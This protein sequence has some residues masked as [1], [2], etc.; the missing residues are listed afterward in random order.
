MTTSPSLHDL[1]GAECSGIGFRPLDRAVC[2]YAQYRGVQ[3]AATGGDEAAAVQALRDKV[4]R[5]LPQLQALREV[6][7]VEDV[8]LVQEQL[9]QQP[10]RYFARPMAPE[11]A[12]LELDLG[13]AGSILFREEGRG[14]FAVVS[15][16]VDG[17][18]QLVHIGEPV[19]GDEGARP[20]PVPGRTPE[21]PQEELLRREKA[22]KVRAL[23]RCPLCRG[24]LLDVPNGL[25]CGPCARDYPGFAGRPVLSVDPGYNPAPRERHV[26]QN[27]YGPQVLDLIEQNRTGLVLDMGSGS[28]SRGFYNVVHLDVFAYEQV[29]V[30]TDGQAL[31]FADETF[32]AV[33]SEAVLEHVPDP[34]AYMKEL[35]RVLKPGGRARVDVAFLQPFHAYPD[36]YY[37][38]TRSGMRVTMERAGLEVLRISVGDHQEPWVAL[39]MM[40]AAFVHGTPDPEKKKSI[41]GTR[42]GEAL[43]RFEKGD[44]TGFRDLPQDQ[45]DRLAAGFSALCEKPR[46][47]D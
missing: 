28:P 47:A 43:A 18:P 23:L 3:L 4:R 2:A 5:F 6:A 7:V 31:P 44:S 24:A 40:L 33:L 29:D 9:G 26:S 30:V 36:H 17:T 14:S 35:V 19:H 41:L 20:L 12:L 38:M 32:D 42:I 1:L 46:R 13:V 16:A 11:R 22:P 39:A 10:L 15:R 34:D 21:P 27:T 37:N 8:H 45:I 25:R